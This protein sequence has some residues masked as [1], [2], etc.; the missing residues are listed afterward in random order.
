M[1]L[2]IKAWAIT[3]LFFL[4][5]DAIWLGVITKSFYASQLGHLMR[6]NVN[7]G[8]AALFYLFFSAAIVYLASY[9]GFKANSATIALIAGA[10]LGLAA[11]GTY[12]ITNMAT[13]K[14][15]P[16]QMSLVDMV[17]GTVITAAS[18]YVGFRAL[19]YFS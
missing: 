7:F 5:V 12:D 11:Y 8:I 9:N 18:S 3:T 1:A 16:I 2:F 17:W 10:V 15:W 6:E 13:L 4:V 19:Q 14:D